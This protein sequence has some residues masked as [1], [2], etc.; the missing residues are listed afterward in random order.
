M[1]F[2]L[3]SLITVRKHLKFRK[4]ALYRRTLQ[5]NNKCNFQLIHLENI[6]IAIKVSHYQIGH[7]GKYKTLK[8]LRARLYWPGMQDDVMSEINSC[9]RC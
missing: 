9:Q 6:R 5:V 2:D 3:Q 1:D 8:L 4:T 7:P